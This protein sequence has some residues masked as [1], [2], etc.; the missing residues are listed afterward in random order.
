[1]PIPFKHFKT[2][3]LKR[4]TFSNLKNKYYYLKR[5]EGLY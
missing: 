1:M 4:K 3:A 5:E 2:S